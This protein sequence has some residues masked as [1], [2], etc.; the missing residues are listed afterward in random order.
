[1]L[2]LA[3]WLERYAS[4][5]APSV[6]LAC[7]IARIRVE[8]KSLGDALPGCSEYMTRVRHRLIPY[9]W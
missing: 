2:G 7:L 4:V 5:I 8:E 1:L 9:V 3:L 6:V